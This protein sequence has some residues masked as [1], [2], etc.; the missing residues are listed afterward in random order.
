[1]ALILTAAAAISLVIGSFRDAVPILAIVC[2]FSMLGFVQEYR[3]DRAIR[4][5]KRLAV[6]SVRVRRDGVISEIIASG[7]VVGDVILLEA[8]NV[9]PADCRL[10]ESY[11]VRVQESL[12]TGEAETVEKKCTPLSDINPPIGD[13]LNMLWM[14]TTT[15]AGRAVALVVATAMDTELGR[16]AEMLQGVQNEWTP[17]QKRLDRMGKKPSWLI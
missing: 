6:P 7:L 4:A 2:L 1:M 14:G 5:L 16:I 10:L 3:A 17:L 12:L 15:I 11:S 9:V 8:G 13:Q